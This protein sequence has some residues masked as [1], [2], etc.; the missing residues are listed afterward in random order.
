[1]TAAAELST[2]A[3]PSSIVLANSD[4]LVFGNVNNFDKLHIR[5]VCQKNSVSIGAQLT[6]FRYL[7]VS[8]IP[9]ALRIFLRLG[10]LP[11]HVVV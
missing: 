1:M 8:T 9:Y 10:F 6:V 4:G 3:Y 11:S 2:S 7:S 5:S